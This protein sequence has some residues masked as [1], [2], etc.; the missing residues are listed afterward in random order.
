MADMP[1]EFWSGWITVI[2]VTSLL[3]LAWVVFSVFF[4]AKGA[5]SEES[6]VWDNTLVEGFNAPPLW[7]FWLILS[8]MICTVVYLILYPGLGSFA[9][10]IRWSQAEHLHHSGMMYGGEFDEVRARIA[11]TPIEM[12]QTDAA[13]MASAQR[14]FR[15]NCA[16]CHGANA[17]G[18]AQMFPNLRDADWQWGGEAKQIEQT[19]RMGRQALMPPHGAVV[20]A[21]ELA[22][23]VNYV[24]ALSSGGPTGSR[25]AGHEL[26]ERTCSACHGLNATGNA[27][28]GAP[29]LTD[30]IWLYGGS[31]EALTTT[32]TNGRSGIMPSFEKRLDDTQIRLLVAWLLRDQNGRLALK[33]AESVPSSK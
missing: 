8:A 28:V 11:S 4:S 13:A 10:V 31:N 30:N 23:L 15:Q 32:I 33:A 18:Q 6:P 12:L 16:A 20:S 26:F 14:V 27:F 1:S 22:E 9:G 17:Q 21:D 24:A 25:E 7:W 2:T 19:I 3:A 5:K 29:N